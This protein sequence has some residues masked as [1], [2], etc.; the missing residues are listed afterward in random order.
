MGNEFDIGS[1]E[2]YLE[3]L[4]AEN[5]KERP[6]DIVQ[7]LKDDHYFGRATESGKVVYPGWWPVLQE[8]FEDDEKY[9]IV[10][11]GAIGT[12]KTTTADYAAGYVL[13]RH[14][15]TTNPRGFYQKSD[16]H[17]MAVTFFNLTKSLGA[18]KAYH[19]LMECISRSPWFKA[20]GAISRQLQ[21]EVKVDIPLFE[22]QLGSPYCFTADTKISLLDGRELEIARVIDE[23][24]QGKDVWCYSYDLDKKMMVPGKVLLGGKTADRA[25]LVKVTLDN[26]EEIKCTCNHLFLK[27]D[28]TYCKAKDLKPDDSLMPLYRKIDPKGYEKFYEPKGGKWLYTHRRTAGSVPS[29]WRDKLGRFI[30]SIVCHHKNYN[31]R[32]NRPTNLE[33]MTGKEHLAFHSEHCAETI[34]SV[35]SRRKARIT[36][37]NHLNDPAWRKKFFVKMSL[38]VKRAW[39][40]E[41]RRRQRQRMVLLNKTKIADINRGSVRSQTSA[42]LKRFY[43]EPAGVRM[44]LQRSTTTSSTMRKW[45]SKHLLKLKKQKEEQPVQFNNHK[46][47]SVELCGYAPVYDI[48]VDK[49][50]NFLLSSGVFVHNSKGFGNIG[51]DTICAILDELDAPGESAG[52]KDRVLKAFEATRR[53]FES[54][55]VQDGCS[56]G[57]LFLVS[58]KQDELS[59]LETYIEKEKVKGAKNV[60]VFDKAKWE[61]V[62]QAYYSGVTFDVNVGDAYHPPKILENESAK[63]EALKDG[64]EVETIPVELK[65]DFETDIIGA[66]RDHAGIAVRGI[67]KHKLFP[68]PRFIQDCFDE[69]KPDPIPGGTFETF[70]EDEVPWMT[71]LDV[72]LI[73]TPLQVPRFIHLDISISH[74]AMAIGMSGIASWQAADILQPDGSFKKAS[75]PIVETD[76]VMRVKARP[77]GRIPLTRMREFILALKA[78]GVN[79]RKFTADLL[80]ASEDTIQILTAAKIPAEYFS[81][82]KTITPYMDWRNLCFEKRWLC[83]SHGWILFEGKNLEHD[84]DKNKI[85]H[86]KEVKELE[87]TEDGRYHDVVLEG[88]KDCTDTVAATVHQALLDSKQPTDIEAAKKVLSHLRPSTAKSGMPADWFISGKSK[89]AMGGQGV[90]TSDAERVAKMKEVLR[91]IPRRR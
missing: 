37:V 81:V 68:S 2:H 70:L 25:K 26:G 38:S 87:F 88:S 75:V 71:H 39:T 83:H 22:W 91:R 27:R 1:A 28:G 19:G 49:H 6:V 78:A 79:I 9:I 60:R 21:N 7:F 43:S 34:H 72:R 13:Y 11:T 15:L 5:Y 48:E 24:G 47:I 30:R 62:S 80:L 53:R 82:D 29:R 74:D 90:I 18:S 52:Q 41:R 3:K 40:P 42:S 64:F 89:A 10:L 23:V 14:M 63:I 20:N 50:S 57:R 36:F 73:R 46:V 67:R 59:F 65:D 86:P 35:D 56:M 77:G 58:S 51:G 44:R 8:M 61:I 12:G 84:R 31:K 69:T 55:F 54:R 4:Y 76:F 33:Y 32:D 45:L 66:L 85:D 16:I 17:R